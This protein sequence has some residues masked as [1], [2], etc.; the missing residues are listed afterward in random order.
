[1]KPRKPKTIEVGKCYRLRRFACFGVTEPSNMVVYVCA[2]EGAKQ[3]WVHIRP[4]D[5]DNA[6][7]WTVDSYSAFLRGVHSEVPNV[8]N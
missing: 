6:P 8:V 4:I 3:R 5:E 1:M 7:G 2:I